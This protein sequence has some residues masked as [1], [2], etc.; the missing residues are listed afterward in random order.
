MA[1]V[2]LTAEMVAVRFSQYLS[3]LIKVPPDKIYPPAL[4]ALQALEKEGLQC[5]VEGADLAHAWEKV[6][7]K[8]P[9]AVHDPGSEMSGLEP[10][11]NDV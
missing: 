8:A 2:R 5:M 1:H 9:V 7:G 6:T 10:K 3:P 4:A 11:F